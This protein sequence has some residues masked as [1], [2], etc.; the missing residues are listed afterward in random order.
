MSSP[1]PSSA[2]TPAPPSELERQYKELFD[3]AVAASKEAGWGAP[4][5]HD[6]L[7]SA[8]QSMAMQAST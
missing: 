4:K 2:Q 5:T 6:E 7:V 1:N 8:L 3:L